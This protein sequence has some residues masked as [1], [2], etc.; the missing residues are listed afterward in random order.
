MVKGFKTKKIE[1]N[2][3]LGEKLRS[4]RIKKEASLAE[5]ES[6]TKVRA[7]FL[8]ALERG[9]WDDLPNEVY[10]RGFVLAYAKYLGIDL[11]QINIDL[12]IET[13]LQ[14]QQE[15]T[16]I[17]YN[18]SVRDVKVLITPKLIGYG[19]LLIF[20]LSMFSYIIYQVSS[21]AGSPVLKIATPSNNQ[22]FETDAIDIDGV[23]DKDTTLTVNDETIPVT[24]D[25]SFTTN[26]KL[27][28]GVN[29]IKVKATNKVQKE[30]S[31]ILTVE[32]KPKT[33]EANTDL[34]RSQ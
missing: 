19:F 8:S 14:R 12:E 16:A 2:Q 11:D 4:A 33:A 30:T 18:N 3:T 27:H 20:V 32:Y 22:I 9:K 26:L 25:G 13:S 21:F 1:S 17:S 15:K 29:V 34:I 10:V 6:A 31:E 23:A 5:A 7:K 24:N 28:R